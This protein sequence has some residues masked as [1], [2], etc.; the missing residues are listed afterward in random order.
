MHGRKYANAARTCDLVFVNSAF[1]G[2]DVVATLGVPPER[3]RVAHPGVRDGLLAGRRRCRPRR[4]VRPHRRHARAAQEPA[5]A[6]RG[7]PACSAATCLLAVA[8]GEG[9]GR[10]AA[11]R[12][13]ADPPA[14]L[15]RRRRAGAPVPRR[16]RRRLSVALRGLRH[17][18]RRGA[19]L[20]LPRRRLA[21][22]S[23]DEASGDGRGARRPGRSGG[24]GGGD[25]AGA[26]ASATRLV[27]ARPGARVAVHLAG[28]RRGLPARL[29]G[30]R[31]VRDHEVAI[32]VSRR[33]RVPRP[34]ARPRPRRLLASARGRRR[35]W[36]ERGRGGRARAG[37]GDRA[38]RA[39]PRPRARARA[40]TRRAAACGSA[41]SPPRRPP[42]W[43]P[44]LDEE[45]V[46]YRWCSEPD[47]LALLRV[48]RAAR[49]ARDAAA[50]RRWRRLVRVGFDTSPFVAD[51]APARRGT[52]RGLLGALAGR[53][54]LE[55]TTALVR[56][57]GQG[58]VRAP[59]RVLV[60]VRDRCCRAR[61]GRAALPDVPRAA[62]CPCAGRADRSRSGHPAPS[63]DLPRL[64]PRLRS[65]RPARDRSRRRRRGRALGVHEGG[66][67]ELLGVPRGSGSGSS[68]TASTRSSPR[69]GRQGRGRL[70]PRGGDA[71][72]AQEPR[73]GA[74][75]RR[76]S[77][78]SS[79]ASSAPA[80]WGG[81]DVS[82]LGR[83]SSPTTSS[84]AST[85]APAASS[86]RRSTRAS[87]CRSS[88]RWRAGRPS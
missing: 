73:P 33:R 67:D 1:T 37:G 58:V 12:R 24:D 84:P 3:V 65:R 10:A 49:R 45:H 15:R 54:G 20:R 13:P 72:A 18:D 82:G 22:P 38:A 43:E 44:V 8:G 62:A 16:G 31:A 57:A 59:R 42:G 52:C 23:M 70:R 64:A 30:G 29:R 5:D 19:R 86:T 75:R 53:T 78:A 26:R 69:T 4:T 34:A 48:P 51:A 71:G 2:E 60:P 76:G 41:C 28:E 27:S 85:A 56:R 63:R 61:A 68:R 36:R 46:E 74:S 80:G 25:R 6:R 7:A 11:A 83:A 21:H 88:R 17:A 40:T 14:R 32:V 9:L 47:A 87:G 39:G 35:A 66:G 81:V 77:P 50:R 79:C 55:L